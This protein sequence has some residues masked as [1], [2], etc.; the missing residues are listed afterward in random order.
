MAVT[1]C[2]KLHQDS[3]CRMR[4]TVSV[5]NAAQYSWQLVAA[6][7]GRLPALAT[8]VSAANMT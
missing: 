5:A 7:A 8:I 1:A 3:V 6:L 2:D 4:R